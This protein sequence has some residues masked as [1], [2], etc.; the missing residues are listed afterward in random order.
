[1]SQL[2]GIIDRNSLVSNPRQLNFTGNNIDKIYD[3]ATVSSEFYSDLAQVY[4]DANEAWRKAAWAAH[5]EDEDEDGS[6]D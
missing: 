4:D 2:I 1:M 3:F 5:E 6:A